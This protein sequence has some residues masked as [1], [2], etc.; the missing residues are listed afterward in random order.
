MKKGGP[1]GLLCNVFVRVVDFNQSSE[2]DTRICHHTVCLGGTRLEL[3]L[4]DSM[5]KRVLSLLWSLKRGIGL[6]FAGI[7]LATGEVQAAGATVG[8]CYRHDRAH[9]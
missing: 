1:A 8:R 3:A 6:S 9:R 4:S 5:A 7:L 2:N